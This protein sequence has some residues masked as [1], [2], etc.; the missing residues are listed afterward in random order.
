MTKRGAEIVRLPAPAPVADPAAEIGADLHRTLARYTEFAVRA[1]RETLADIEKQQAGYVAPG[2]RDDLALLRDLLRSAVDSLERVGKERSPFLAERSPR[3]V[4]W[5]DLSDEMARDREA[6]MAL[7]GVVKQAAADELAMGRTAAEAVEPHHSGPWQRARFFAVRAALGDGLQPRN[8]MEALLID[9]MA[10]A[11]TMH[12]HWLGR[13]AVMGSADAI[14]AERTLRERGEWEPPRLGEAEAVDRA[15][16]MADRFQRQFLRL[17]KCYRDGRRLGVS[18]T[19]TGG[20]VNVAEQ[21]IVLNGTEP[22]Q[23]GQN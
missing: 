5:Y 7:W 17:M 8:R 9:G 3:D 2:E 4:S 6:G 21:Q 19:V 18:M 15:A 1:W 13:H 23:T 11:W 12:L 20:Q 14:R 22:D 16:L 10:Q